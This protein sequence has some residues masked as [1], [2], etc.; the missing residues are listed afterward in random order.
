MKTRKTSFNQSLYRSI[1]FMIFLTVFICCMASLW[2]NTTSQIR[3]IESN[4]STLVTSFS[5]DPRIFAL[6]SDDQVSEKA[7]ADIASIIERSENIDGI[8][9]FRLDGSFAYRSND[10]LPALSEEE[11]KSCKDLGF[12]QVDLS[13]KKNY[14]GVRYRRVMGNIYDSDGNISGYVAVHSRY[15]RQYSTVTKTIPSF[16]LVMFVLLISGVVIGASYLHYMKN[17]LNGYN[18]EQYIALYDRGIDILNMLE[19]GLLTINTEGRLTYI[20][21]F[22]RSLLKLPPNAEDQEKGYYIQELVPNSPLMEVIETGKTKYNTNFLFHGAHVLANQFPLYRDGEIIGALSVFRTA[23]LITELSEQLESA[24][25]MVDT[26]R[27]YNHEYQN[28]L[29]VILGYLETG[30]LDEA[31]QFLLKGSMKS[32]LKISNISSQIKHQGIAALLIGKLIKANEFGISLTITPGS[33]CDATTK[34]VTT[35]AYITI[36]GNL[37]E[38]AIEELNDIEQEEKEI[39]LTL[40]IN[41]SQTYI[42][43]LDTGRGMPP[44]YIET[45]TQ[46]GISTKGP[47][48]GTGLYLINN[49]LENLN[50]SIRFE[51]EPG[52]GTEVIVMIN[53]THQ[54][55]GNT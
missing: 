10:L 7:F 39:Q 33:Y 23:T 47:G 6:L 22:A 31:K 11:I 51:S 5:D 55:G 24:N 40:Y 30:Q 53:S 17:L 45:I 9:I 20:N 4:L 14:N 48:R 27:A 32:S 38:N 46:F 37:L 3:L 44:E 21:D 26:L 18:L 25:S 41:E 29:H 36:L 15:S 8:T 35:N 12:D 49:L 42:S 52:E 19:E 28:N 13:T 50:G 54:T 34:G 16:A 2:A 1:F 43:V